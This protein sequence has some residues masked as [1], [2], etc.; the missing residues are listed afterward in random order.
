MCY[1]TQV[2]RNYE[3]KVTKFTSDSDREFITQVV[4]W[5]Y[6]ITSN[7]ETPEEEDDSMSKLQRYIE[8]II[9]D[10]SVSEELTH[11]TW[12][13]IAKSFVPMLPGL[14]NASFMRTFL[15]RFAD[16][17]FVESENAELAKNPLAPKP[18]N[19]LNVSC[20]K[21]LN[22]TKVRMR[23][24]KSDAANALMSQC[25]PFTDDDGMDNSLTVELSKTVC[26]L[27]MSDVIKEYESRTGEYWCICWSCIFMLL[28]NI[29]A[30]FIPTSSCRFHGMRDHQRS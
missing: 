15:G 9:Q 3:T 28:S 24:I 25:T 8:S 13:F 12:E 20:D 26:M 30:L 19:S 21:L 4:H 11:T 2:N 5:L 10:K 23:S 27:P 7:V 17:G 29:L 18:N 14:S 16:T 1:F 22:M 6:H